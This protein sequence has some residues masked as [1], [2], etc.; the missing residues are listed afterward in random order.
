MRRSNGRIEEV[1][2]IQDPASPDGVM[3]TEMTGEGVGEGGDL[4][5]QLPFGQLGELRRITLAG[6]EGL[7]HRP[8]GLGEDLGGHR[9][10]LDAGVLKTFSRRWISATRAS[11]WVLR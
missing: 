3:I 2:V 10:Q 4:R 1:H 8:A 6:N 5:S 7:D 11:I 9:G